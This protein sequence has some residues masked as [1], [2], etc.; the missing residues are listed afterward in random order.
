M[1]KSI[2]E[3]RIVDYPQ[4]D[5]IIAGMPAI[6]SLN[7]MKAFLQKLVKERQQLSIHTVEEGKIAK[8]FQNAAKLSPKPAK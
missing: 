2:D 4:G 8:T 6:D 3:N 5:H 1:Q 7:E